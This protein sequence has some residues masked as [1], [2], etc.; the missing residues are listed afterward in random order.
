MRSLDSQLV[1]AIVE[2]ERL[3]TNIRIAQSL[4]TLVDRGLSALSD[5]ERY[6]L[7]K[8]YMSDCPRST[9][10]L[11]ERL[12]YSQRSL[13]RVRDRALRKFTLAM[14]GVEIT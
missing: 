10:A 5:D 6:V 11:L 3:K 12:G 8:L 1:D 4:I 7:E 2:T 14:Y 9:R 13:Y